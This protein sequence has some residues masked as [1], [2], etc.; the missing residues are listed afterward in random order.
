[1][2]HGN[3]V[4]A[5]SDKDADTKPAVKR[6]KRSTE[7]HAELIRTFCA[8]TIDGEATDAVVDAIRD[9]ANRLGA[10]NWVEPH[11]FHITLKFYG[12]IPE[13][14]LPD[15]ARAMSAVAGPP[16]RTALRGMGGFPDLREPR[17]LWIGVDDSKG[18][19]TKLYRRI[20][21]VSA[22]LGFEAEDRR[23]RPHISVARVKKGRSH[24]VARELT[25]L[26]GLTFAETTLREIALMTS[27]M[28]GP[29]ALGGPEYR[30]FERVT[31]SGGVA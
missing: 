16:I 31:L 24:P 12:A 20:N 11:K 7:R 1:M 9:R 30:V 22:Q 26:M 23:F 5:K 29:D 18:L 3:A 27:H 19:I 14:R 17:V 21:D 28:P 2:T 13:D 8:L 4:A 15:L 6:R 25:P 10:F